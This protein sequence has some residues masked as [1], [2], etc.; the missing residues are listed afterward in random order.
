V[1]NYHR[2]DVLNRLKPYWLH[3]YLLTYTPILLLADSNITALWQQWMLG[4]LT[5]A[6]TAA[7]WRAGQPRVAYLTAEAVL[8]GAMAAVSAVVLLAQP[9]R[10]RRARVPAGRPVPRAWWPPPYD[11][12]PTLA[13]CVGTPLAL[14]AGAALAVFR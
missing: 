14:G 6:L 11:P 13:V 2:Q 5:F 7:L 4:L 10:W 9:A 1:G 8:L 12:L 3:A